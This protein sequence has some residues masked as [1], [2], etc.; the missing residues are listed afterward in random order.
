MSETSGASGG[1]VVLG[2][3]PQAAAWMFASAFGVGGAVAT[4]LLAALIDTFHV[5]TPLPK[6]G[7]MG[8]PYSGMLVRFGLALLALRFA[9]GFSGIGVRSA[10]RREGEGPWR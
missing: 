1:S 5:G 2:L 4:A 9:S 7:S 3:N 8:G 10:V 6:N